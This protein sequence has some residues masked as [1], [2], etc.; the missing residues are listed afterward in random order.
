MLQNISLSLSDVYNV[1]M[2][3]SLLIH[4]C[5]LP[6]LL[7]RC[8]CLPRIAALENFIQFLQGSSL[9]L[10]IEEVDEDEFK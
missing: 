4:D 2:F 8:T 5:S 1:N 3:L 6:H 7:N 10:N 9:R